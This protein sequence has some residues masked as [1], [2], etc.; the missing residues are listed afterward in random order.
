MKEVNS[1]PWKPKLNAL[2]RPPLQPSGDRLWRWRARLVEILLSTSS[3]SPVSDQ[4]RWHR[5]TVSLPR[6]MG[7]NTP[8]S[9]LKEAAGKAVWLYP[10]QASFCH[11]N[12]DVYSRKTLCHVSRYFA[13]PGKAPK[14]NTSQTKQSSNSMTIN[15]IKWG[16]IL[17][18]FV[19]LILM[20]SKL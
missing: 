6:K 11:F 13:F 10:V 15:T 1:S 3:Q 18:Q 20:A 12:G 19:S 8:E 16:G 7:A 2:K 14:G 4:V 5:C 17:D 9:H